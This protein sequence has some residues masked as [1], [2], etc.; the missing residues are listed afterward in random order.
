MVRVCVRCIPC[1][2]GQY[3][4]PKSAQCQPCPAGT[5]AH[6]MNV[7]GIESCIRCGE[8]LTALH[9][10]SCVTSCQYNS[11]DGRQYDFTPLS[12]Y[13]C[14]H[15]VHRPLNCSPAPYFW[16]KWWH[17]ELLLRISHMKDDK[18]LQYTVWHRTVLSSWTDAQHTSPL[19]HQYFTA[20]STLSIFAGWQYSAVLHIIQYF[21]TFFVSILLKMYRHD[22]SP[23]SSLWS[24]L[25]TSC[26]W[27]HRNKQTNKQTRATQNRTSPS[28]NL[29]TI[30]AWG[31]CN[32][33]VRP[34]VWCVHSVQTVNGMHLFTTTG[35]KYF[36]S[37]QI[38]LCAGG[39]DARDFPPAICVNNASLDMQVGHITNYNTPMLL[40]K[41]LTLS[42][43]MPQNQQSHID[44]AHTTV[45]HVTVNGE[46]FDCD[47]DPTNLSATL[48][49]GD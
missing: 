8:G 21:M 22:L 26:D 32:Q 23:V 48:R 2:Q 24:E 4:D 40:V 43:V 1:P 28:V 41:T 38:S 45:N 6:G 20:S 5:V 25:T 18:W 16:S 33:Q 27:R 36:R 35:Y 9:G 19:T 42:C 3:V 39:G 7:W 34:C 10:T 11:T 14:M 49:S 47:L 13:V 31:S 15:T 30:C 46:T 29:Y 37:F 17:V 12:G 44:H